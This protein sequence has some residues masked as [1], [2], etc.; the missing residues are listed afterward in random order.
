MIF[1]YKILHLYLVD[2]GNYRQ[3]C[4]ECLKVICNSLG[5]NTLN[6]S[7]IIRDCVCLH[8]S[9]L[10]SNWN[11]I[12]SGS[13]HRQSK[14]R[15]GNAGKSANVADATSVMRP[16]TFYFGTLLFYFKYT[17]ELRISENLTGTAVSM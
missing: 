11:D 8:E 2:D 4:V 1:G 3:I 14:E 10:S 5:L 16:D 17:S 13:N 7:G 15:T 12:Q 9:G 6:E